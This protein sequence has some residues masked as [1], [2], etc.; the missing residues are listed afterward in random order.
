MR[1]SKM[2]HEYDTDGLLYSRRVTLRHSRITSAKAWICPNPPF[3]QLRKVLPR[4]GGRWAKG[5][6]LSQESQRIG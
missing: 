4:R 2:P 6:S 5:A 3:L 1:A